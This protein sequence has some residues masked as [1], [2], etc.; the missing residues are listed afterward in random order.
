[1]SAAI[2]SSLLPGRRNQAL[3]KFLTSSAADSWELVNWLTHDRDAAKP[4]SLIAAQAVDALIGHSL[5]A[6]KGDAKK[7][8][9]DC[10]TCSSRRIR[11]HF[12]INIG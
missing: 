1:M 12:D 4:P 2:Y 6:F 11:Q 7:L 10:P 8:V 5:F 3:R 9:E